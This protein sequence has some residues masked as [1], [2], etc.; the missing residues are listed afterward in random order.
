MTTEE[1]LLCCA[2]LFLF[3]LALAWGDLYLWISTSPNIQYALEVLACLLVIIVGV[4]LS[5]KYD[6]RN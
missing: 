4:W 1:K 2:G 5:E 3:L 6:E